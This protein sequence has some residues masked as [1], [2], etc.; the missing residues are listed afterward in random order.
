MVSDP[1]FQFEPSFV[2]ENLMGPN[3][4]SLMD[5]TMEK[6]PLKKGMR[7]LDLGSGKALTSIVL[8]KK[9]DVTV[10]SVDL[11]I[12]ATENYQRIKEFGL[13]DQVIP[14]H[15]EATALP[16]ADDYFDAVV[17][18]DCYHYF[19]N[20]STYFEEKLSKLMK[21]D[22]PLIL[23]IPGLKYDIHDNVPE[24]LGQFLNAEGLDTL[25][26]VDWWKKTFV[27]A[28]P[29]FKLEDMYELKCTKAA[30]KDWLE[31]DHEIA[32]KDRAMIKAENGQYFNFIAI[33]GFKQ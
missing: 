14:I 28:S 27:D 3:C 29:S 20:N 18:M 31:C 32:I 19:G 7:V 8:A 1:N 16:F 6:F 2:K 23:T 10:Y 26:C 22:A 12:S 11:W 30:W 17:C 13:E 9:Y 33:T 5:E 24:A 15:A 4:L 21:K 25:H